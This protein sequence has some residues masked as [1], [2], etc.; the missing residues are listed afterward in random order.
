MK[1]LIIAALA[2]VLPI[3]AAMAQQEAEPGDTVSLYGGGAQGVIELQEPELKLLPVLIFMRTVIN[4]QADAYWAQAGSLD[5]EGGDEVWGAPENDFEWEDQLWRAAILMEAGNSLFD[6]GRMRNGRCVEREGASSC[7]A[8][9]NY[10]AQEL[11]DG[12]EAGMA[13]ARAQDPVAAFNAGSTI[14]DACYGCHA[15]FIPRPAASRYS[16]DFPTDEE[17]QDSGRVLGD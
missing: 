10:Y 1:K 17:L 6:E 15:R 7:D 14:Y 13:A 4:P 8:V 11:I 5:D 9:W 12:G 16:G 2:L 3:G